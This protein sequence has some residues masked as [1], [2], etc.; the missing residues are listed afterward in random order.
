[1]SGKQRKW[2]I[3]FRR[4]RIRDRLFAAMIFL[5]LP[6]LFFLGFL[7][8]NVARDTLTES[9][10][11]SNGD[12]LQT[13][14]EVAD[15]LFRNIINLNRFIVLNDEILGDLRNSKVR[16]SRE[17]S[18][19]NE[20]TINR[21]QRVINS[22]SF[23]TRFVDS[24]CIFDL[25]Y[26]T[27]C[28]G[29]PDNA[30]KYEGPDKKT[31]IEQSDWYR[32]AVEAQGR[33]LFFSYN[34]L[35]GTS[36]SFSTVKLFRDSESIE[37][38]PLGLLVTNLSVSM[39][40]NVSQATRDYGHFVVVDATGDAARILYPGAWSRSR[41]QPAAYADLI[42]RWE[43]EGYLVS[44]YRNVTTG[45]HFLHLVEKAELLAKSNRI[46]TYT[47]LIAVLIAVVALTISYLVSGGITRP[48]L[49]LKKMMVDWN[50]GTLDF[51]VKFKDDEVGTIGETF[52]RVAQTNME[53][54][55][56]LIQAELR[57]R[58]AELRALQAQINPHFLYNT[59]DSIY[60]MA[61]LKKTEEAA[62][63]ALALSESFKLSL[64]KGKETIPV[65]K[66]LKHVEHYMTIQNIRYKGRIRYE[67]DVEADVQGYE[68]LKLILQPLVENAVYHGLEP[69]MG[70]G[71]IRIA[72]RKNGDELIFIVE[73]DGVGMED[74][75]LTEQGYGLRNVRER[76]RLYYGS[77]YSFKIRS[78]PGAGTRIEIRF[79]PD[80]GGTMH[81][82]SGRV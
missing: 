36:S 10:L 30:G 65:F 48:L 78:S 54:D 19:M 16:N 35:D 58:E 24:L 75:T 12:H 14:S 28:L 39:F 64:N 40:Q 33:V 68:M 52:L 45:W 76:L 41:E 13:T 81:V 7:S 25:Y 72:G 37:G 74:A 27:Y 21:L 47:G 23:D 77:H 43:A 11:E 42:A 8:F 1:M 18:E 61:R 6:P 26:Q 38:R 73:D 9:I 80:R 29:R 56:R 3:R 34:V 49:Q 63:M 55:A 69:K 67:I 66:E 2:M 71:L 32:A 51:N 50:K 20:L 5:S 62:T 60:W 53:L 31:R 17:L 70:D 59:L 46:G 57:E 44:D 79:K 15:L 4:L 82:E 22:N